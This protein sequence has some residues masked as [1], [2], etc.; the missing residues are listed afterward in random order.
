VLDAVRI[1]GRLISVHV[2]ARLSARST[3]DKPPTRRTL[4]HDFCRA[5]NWRNRK[6]QLCLASANVAL[7]R[8]E[9]QGLVRLSPPQRF[10]PLTQP[11]KL[12]DD[13]QSLPAL[14]KVSPHTTITLQLIEGQADPQHLLWNRLIIREHPLKD[15]PLVGSQLRYLIRCPEGIIGAFGVGPPAFHL[16][17]RDSWIGWDSQARK[18]NLSQVI[19]L[20]RFLIRPGIRC[21][22]LASRC[23]SLLLRRVAQD[24]QQRY[25]IKPVLIETFVD[26]TLHHGISLGASNWRRLGQSS[27]R[28]RSTV[29]ARVHASTVKDVWVYELCAKARQCLLRTTEPLVP[30]RSIFEA[31]SIPWT[32]EE[33][34]GLDLGDSR[35]NKRLPELLSSRWNHPQ[36]SFC[37]SFESLAQTKAAYRLIE[38]SCAQI[39]FQS[40][41]A[42]HQRQ[43]QRRMAAETVVLLPQDTTTL[44]YNSLEHTEGLGQIGDKRNPGR[45]LLLHSM[46]AFRPDGIP[47]GNAWAKI[48]ARPYES[49]CSRRNQQS[50]SEKE[51]ARWIE[52]Y[53]AA[54]KIA[55]SMPQTH[56]VVCGDRESDIFDLF[57]QG[58]DAPKNLHFLVRAQHDRLLSSGEKL[59]D[60]LW[61][62]PVQGIRRVLVPRRQD[63]PARVASLE[64]RWSAMEMASPQVTVKRKWQPVAL[65]AVFAQE[66]NPPAGVEPIHWVLL[67]DWKVQS[68][69]MAIRLIKWYSR[70]W[71]IECWHQ[72]LKDVCKIEKRQMKSDEALQ[73][74]LVLDLIVA[75][76]VQMLVRLGKEQ[77]TLPASLLYAPEELAVLE[78]YK[79]KLPQHARGGE[80]AGIAAPPQELTQNKNQPELPAPVCSPLALTLFQANLLVAMLVGFLARKNDGHPGAKVLGE[81]LIILAALVEDRR[82]AGKDFPRLPPG[83]KRPREPD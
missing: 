58:Q 36:R 49:D 82:M 53:Q 2:L 76:R 42:P 19:G 18:A 25:G 31:Q 4:V 79:K 23:Y 74:A 20:S 78:D 73:R 54:A 75:W 45:G 63:Q 69:K 5:V 32:E 16:E 37:R 80:E 38:S 12:R 52:A 21:P 68:L 10:G 41:L 17:C 34:D 9:K 11:R 33:F 70:R 7:N 77:P 22:N 3:S 27:G 28:G 30:A 43:T 15:A 83:G 56:L 24:W 6:G 57:D 65:Y 59:W 71:G 50:L 8:L 46:Q 26:R 44:S 48:W 64:V 66:I 40:L 60:H 81:G 13:K 29:S 55:R 35:L 61:S 1:S 51:S 14:A 62:Q 67:T 39:S 72:V 47:L